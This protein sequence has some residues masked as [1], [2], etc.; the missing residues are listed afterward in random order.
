MLIDRLL[1]TS[2]LI[3]GEYQRGCCS[4]AYQSNDSRRSQQRLRHSQWPCLF[5]FGGART[6]RAADLMAVDGC[7]D[8][9]LLC[10]GMQHIRLMPSGSFRIM[11]RFFLYKNAVHCPITATID[12]VSVPFETVTVT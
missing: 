5:A 10:H 6:S 3:T 7:Y 4:K 1:T 9:I 11:L 8:G 2:P 12:T